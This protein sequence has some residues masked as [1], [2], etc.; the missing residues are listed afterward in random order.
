VSG[1]KSFAY[2]D[3]GQIHFITWSD[4]NAI[5]AKVKI[6]KQYGLKG[7]AIF[8]IDGEGDKNMWSVLR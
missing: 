1:E 4:A 6:S 5:Q 2:T 3:K 8:K 7:V